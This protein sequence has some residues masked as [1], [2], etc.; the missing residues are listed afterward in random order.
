MSS[1]RLAR[2][3]LGKVSTRD[4][5]RDLATLRG[6][7]PSADGPAPSADTPDVAAALADTGDFPGGSHV[8]AAVEVQHLPLR[9]LVPDGRDDG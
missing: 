2:H 1:A 9:D 5:P 7:Y 6:G 8:A 4:A 3:P